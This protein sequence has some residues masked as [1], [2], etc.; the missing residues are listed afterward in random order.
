MYTKWSNNFQKNASNLRNILEEKPKIWC[1]GN[2]IWKEAKNENWLKKFSTEALIIYLL[3]YL[4]TQWI[5]WICILNENFRTKPLTQDS[6]KK[7]EVLFSNVFLFTVESYRLT[8]YFYLKSYLS[9]F[10]QYLLL[11]CIF[12]FS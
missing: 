2:G 8:F 11:S 6:K 10:T 1:A 3:R 12:S 4:W 7:K 9:S 5:A